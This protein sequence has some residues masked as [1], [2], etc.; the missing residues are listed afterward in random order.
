MSLNFLILSC[1]CLSFHLSS[2]LSNLLDNAI[3]AAQQIHNGYIKIEIFK[4][5]A[6]YGICVENSFLGKNSIV[7]N[8]SQLLST[9]SN[10]AMHGYGTPM[11]KFL[12]QMFYWKFN[13]IWQNLIV[14]AQILTVQVKIGLILHIFTCFAAILCDI[15]LVYR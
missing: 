7:H 6:Y 3:E 1:C 11:E 5:K 9:K 10:N 12:N 14:Q 2:L 8:G 13:K 4:Y 15:A